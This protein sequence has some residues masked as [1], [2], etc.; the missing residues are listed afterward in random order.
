MSVPNS[1]SILLPEVDFKINVSFVSMSGEITEFTTDK[2]TNFYSNFYRIKSIN[3]HIRTTGENN[4]TPYVNITCE[5]KDGTV[6]N[7]N[8][9]CLLDN[10]R[11]KILTY[12]SFD[13]RDECIIYYVLTTKIKINVSYSYLNHYDEDM[14]YINMNLETNHQ[15]NIIVDSF[16]LVHEK[17]NEL[18]ELFK[19]KEPD[20]ISDKLHGE[21]DYVIYV[22]KYYFTSET[23]S[24]K[25]SEIDNYETFDSIY[26]FHPNDVDINK[27]F[28]E[29]EFKNDYHLE[30]RFLPIEKDDY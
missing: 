27:S 25:D 7:F 19:I 9:C 14:E 21:L 13:I 16:E 11:K 28:N 1:E 20:F 12:E 26:I 4:Q 17:I 8:D 15:C 23:I 24:S 3:E 5:N 2:R 30:I 22:S 6:K 29:L 10:H 18:I